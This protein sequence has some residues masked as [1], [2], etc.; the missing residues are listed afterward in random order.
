V[1][2][3]GAPDGEVAA[4][5]RAWR[6]AAHRAVCDVIEPWAHATV[7]RATR[8]P[9][10][11]DFNVVR[12]EGDPKLS[13]DALAAFADEALAGLAH[14]RVDLEQTEW[15]E[16]LRVGFKALGWQT[17][18]LVWMRHEAPAPS[19]PAIPV[20]RVPYEAVNDLRVAWHGE[21]FP[22]DPIRDYL[23]EERE[24][25]L[26]RGAEVL[27]VRETGTPV[28]FA[29]LASNGRSAEIE[30]VYVSPD[31]R[32]NGLGTALTRTA[33][34]AAGH[35][36]DLWI[37]ADDEGRPKHLYSRLGFRPAWKAIEALRLL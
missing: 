31:H 20:E 4:R 1:G 11:W 35:V 21:D 26:L 23:V 32:G 15:A 14:R 18:R 22:D 2:G 17:E 8:Y 5:A 7:V 9:S 3:H 10:Y 27:A 12:V 13:A 28:A 6:H 36:Q 30:Q 16:S 19:G 29:Q 24:V 33:I 34:T 25:G 37:V